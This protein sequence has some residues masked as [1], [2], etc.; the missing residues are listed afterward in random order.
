M[1][2]EDMVLRGVLSKVR[3]CPS[4][5]AE[6]QMRNAVR[7]WCSRT[8]CLTQPAQVITSNASD[9]IQ[10]ADMY[11]VDVVDAEIDGETI[12]VLAMND[13][14]VTDASDTCPVL[15]FAEPGQI[16]MVPEPGQPVTVDLLV[17]VS[18]GPDSTEAP[19]VLWQRFKEELLHGALYRLLAQEGETWAKP[20]KAAW[21]LTQW[22]AAIAR[23]AGISGKNRLTNAQRLRSTP[24]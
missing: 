3:G 4:I 19:D 23:Q 6:D 10:V 8:R 13:P 18:P 16:Q 5:E 1:L 17:V 11:V 21:H 7:E 20:A 14:R 12:S 22:Q 2:Y 9:P 24:V 15:I